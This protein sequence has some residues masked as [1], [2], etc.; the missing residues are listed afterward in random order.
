MAG[1]D[2]RTQKVSELV[3]PYHGNQEGY[4]RVF[5]VLTLI[6]GAM[7]MALPWLDLRFIANRSREGHHIWLALATDLLCL[8]AWFGFSKV[9]KG[10]SKLIAEGGPDARQ[11]DSIRLSLTTA[12]SSAA[13]AGL[14]LH[15]CSALIK[16]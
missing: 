4:G 14:M 6:E 13:F 11:L 15:M 3:G 9:Y 2:V 12:A 8:A 16:R 1:S 10:L 7:A 5:F